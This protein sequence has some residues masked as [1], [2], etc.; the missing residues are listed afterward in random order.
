MGSTASPSRPR[1]STSSTCSVN[2]FLF[3]VPIGIS[4]KRTVPWFVIMRGFRSCSYCAMKIIPLTQGKVALVDDGD[5]DRLNHHRWYASKHAGKN[6]PRW[7]ATRMLSS[8]SGVRKL[9]L[10]HREIA[11]VA[12][13]PTVDH[14]DGDG[15][16][17]RR[18]NLRPA[19]YA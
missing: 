2:V 17:N 10:M 4:S 11:A 9:L 12:G 13:I 15:L 5:Y 7:Y 14:H 3:T 8:K 19:T 6:R 1:A 16:N 18:K